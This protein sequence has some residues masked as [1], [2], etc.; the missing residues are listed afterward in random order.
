MKKV[1]PN[2]ASARLKR[3]F[4]RK[5]SFTMAKN[6]TKKN[7]KAVEKA[8]SL[9]AQEMTLETALI[10]MAQAGMF[11]LIDAA[12]EKA[13]LAITPQEHAACK[14][15]TAQEK[16]DAA[17]KAA[18]VD[19]ASLKPAQAKAGKLAINYDTLAKA[20]GKLAVHIGQPDHGNGTSLITHHIAQGLLAGERRFSL[21]E[22]IKTVNKTYTMPKGVP[23]ASTGHIN[24]IKRLLKAAGFNVQTPSGFFIVS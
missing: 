5:E 16:A 23:Y 13:G 20:L 17:L 22:L 8:E 11:E 3:K 19:L 21:G 18:G 10:F 7:E 2:K 4:E 12:I 24:T 9:T 6:S 14:P 1:A 15:L